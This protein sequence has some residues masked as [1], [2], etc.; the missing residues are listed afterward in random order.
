MNIHHLELFF[1][2]AKFEGITAAV[3]K[4]PY[5]IQ[6]PA[7]S[8]QLLQLEEKLGVKLFNRR[9]FALTPAGEE[10][11]DY[12]YPFFS[13]LRDVE[14]RLRGEESQHLRLAASASTLRNHLPDVLEDLKKEEPNLRLSLKEVDPS[15]VHHLLT[16]QQVDVAVSVLAGKLASGLRCLP[17]VEIPVALLVPSSLKAKSL[18]D[19]VDED[20]YNP[21]RSIGR[22]P[23]VGLPP[24][25]VLQQLFQNEFEQRKITWT[26]S[27]EVNSMEVIRDYVIRGFGVGLGLM[28]PGVE[29]PQ[30][31]KAIPLKEFPPLVIGALYQGKPK[32]LVT[33]FLATAQ[34]HAKS[35]A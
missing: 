21:K 17:L 9:P 35:M 20:P 18:S 25:E 24:H 32:V 3:R 12:C 34:K 5:G 7:V 29:M 26:T 11:Y 33:R 15:D 19:L 6:Q 30:G 1:Y 2:V 31:L 14:E 27:V 28:I 10:L 22:E 23:L 4:M 16:S 13:R 8:G